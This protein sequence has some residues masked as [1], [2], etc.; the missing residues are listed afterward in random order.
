MDK[1]RLGGSGGSKR[2][3]RPPEHQKDQN[4]GK[5][6]RFHGKTVSLSKKDKWESFKL[7][8]ARGLANISIETSG[9]K[10]FKERTTNDIVSKLNDSGVEA[11]EFKEVILESKSLQNLISKNKTI[12]AEG[13]INVVRDIFVSNEFVKNK[14]IGL[15]DL[16]KAHDF[17]QGVKDEKGEEGKARN[18]EKRAAMAAIEKRIGEFSVKELRDCMKKLDTKTQSKQ[19]TLI[20]KQ[21]ANKDISA[22]DEKEIRSVIQLQKMGLMGIDRG[23][24]RLESLYSHLID[25]GKSTAEDYFAIGEIYRKSPKRENAEALKFYKK[26][27]KEN[28]KG[29]N[30]L[31][32]VQGLYEDKGIAKDVY[33]ENNI[34]SVLQPMINQRVEGLILDSSLLKDGDKHVGKLP[35][36]VSIFRITDNWKK[37]KANLEIKIKKLPVEQRKIAMARLGE[38]EQMVTYATVMKNDKWKPGAIEKLVAYRLEMK[39]SG[40]TDRLPSKL[41]AKGSSGIVSDENNKEFDHLRGRQSIMGDLSTFMHK[42]GGDYSIIGDWFNG[43]AQNSWSNRSQAMK[44]QFT[45][46]RNTPPRTYFYLHGEKKAANCRETFIND[47]A[48]DNRISPREA[49]KRLDETALMWMA[50]NMELLEKT[51]LPGKNAK[52][53]TIKIYR[54]ENETVIS[55]RKKYGTK[56]NIYKMKSGPIESGSIESA[57][58]SMSVVKICGYEETVQNIP[59]HRCCFGTYLTETILGSGETGL[60]CDSER[61]ILFMRDDIQFLYKGGVPM[62]E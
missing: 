50:F 18:S 49:K 7:F 53:G 6:G 40:I 3:F 58:P 31:M 59:Y 45:S 8:I 26:G 52:R 36:G 57:N 23:N 12:K 27:L 9:Y 17:L 34:N 4:A 10:E 20:L 28:P 29:F 14:N 35:K 56:Q 19:M 15:E 30:T 16:L 37:N 41:T 61:E 47:I 62:K 46:Y 21:I 39:S 38:V 43:Q 25:L 22:L 54:S 51:N 5:A 11:S 24:Q 60:A 42:R 1:G 44:A 33:Y 32:A 55:T 13:L 48:K 2:I